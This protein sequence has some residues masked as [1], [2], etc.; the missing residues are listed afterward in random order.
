MILVSSF[1]FRCRISPVDKIFTINP[2]DK[3]TD[4]EHPSFSFSIKIRSSELRLQNSD[5]ACDFLKPNIQES[6]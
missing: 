2:E 1:D 4:K 3:E 5:P 6:L